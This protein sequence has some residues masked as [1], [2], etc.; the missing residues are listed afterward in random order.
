M[1][2]EERRDVISLTEKEITSNHAFSHRPRG[3]M[4]ISQEPQILL[5]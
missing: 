1:S 2:A 4:G 5:I 3:A